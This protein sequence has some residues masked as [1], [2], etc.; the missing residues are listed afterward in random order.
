MKTQPFEINLDGSTGEGG[1]QILRSALSLSAI[2]GR[3][4]RIDNIRAGRKRP[5]LMRQHLTCVTAAAKVSNAKTSEVA[6]G[7]Q[8]LEFTPGDIQ[9]SNDE[10]SIGTAGSISLLL[11]TL[12][13][14]LLHAP[15]KSSVTLKGG[16]HA[17]HAPS[18]EYIDE[19]YLPMLARARGIAEIHLE[20]YG[21]FPAGGGEVTLKT[22]PSKL[23]P[24]DCI[25]T[26]EQYMVSAEVINTPGIHESVAVRE[27]ESVEASTPLY[28]STE[29]R[30]PES[31]CQG[32]LLLLRAVATNPNLH[33]PGTLVCVPGEKN[34][35]SERV[36]KEAA[37]QMRRF[38][39]SFAPVDEFLADQLLLPLALAGGGQYIASAITPHFK[40]HV[41]IIEKFLPVGIETEKLDRFAWRVYIQNQ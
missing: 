4:F 28:Q 9:A 1:G 26:D 23:V 24:F 39:N 30:V 13:P 31:H 34:K 37:H 3:S 40:S 36:G 12:L 33:C 35:R 25:E 11:Q 29:T 32:N 18:I 41:E 27:I 38:T 14:I 8:T 22:Q 10:F 20:K 2:T 5:G 17:L 16:T 19:I 21:F 6:I 15:E 7:T